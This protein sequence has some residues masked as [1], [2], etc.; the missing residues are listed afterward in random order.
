VR[1]R[2]VGVLT[3]DLEDLRSATHVIDSKN[4]RVSA[5]RQHVDVMPFART[6]PNISVTP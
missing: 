6:R 3:S 5:R 1:A 4:L 2:V